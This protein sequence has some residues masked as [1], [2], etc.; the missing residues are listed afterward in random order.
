MN[1]NTL[2]EGNKYFPQLD[3]LRGIAILMVL[4]YHYFQNTFLCDLGWSG[5]DL[6]F[7]LSGFLITSRLLPYI[8]Y[9]KSIQHFYRNRFLRIV[10]L[11]FGFLIIFFIGW[12]AFTSKETQAANPFYTGH[13]WQFFLF[14]QNWV[15]I[16][17]TTPTARHLMHLW[18]VATEEQFYL[19]FPVFILLVKQRKKLLLAAV[20][21]MAL[22]ATGR[23]LFFYLSKNVVDYETVYFNTFFRID[24]FAGGIFLFL[25]LEKKKNLLNTDKA[26]QYLPGIIVLLMAIPVLIFRSPDKHTEFFSTVG[27]TFIAL[28]YTWV[29]FVTITG[30]NR[31]VNTI[32][33]SKFLRYTGK[34]SYGIYIFHYPLFQFGFAFLSKL[35]ALLHITT[36]TSLLAI[37]NALICIPLTF[38]ISHLSYTY[39]E[40][41]FLKLKV[42][43]NPPGES[44]N[45]DK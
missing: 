9:K 15:F 18:S 2:L 16:Y 33:T 14:I 20:T 39:F 8:N 36:D 6:F 41:R 34:I 5:V 26:N 44:M 27:Y 32:T 24:S 13:W 31:L 38:L 43:M 10:P 22:A 45:T 17:D 29:L 4:C 40:S 12:F 35:Y 21:V 42:T 37:S 19:L 11:Y 1:N 30:R 28:I 25:L 7:V 3:G 23:C